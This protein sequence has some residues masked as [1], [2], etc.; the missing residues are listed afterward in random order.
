MELEEGEVL[1]GLC[2]CYQIPLPLPGT[3]LP[4]LLESLLSAVMV[5]DPLIALLLVP[6]C[7]LS[8]NLCFLL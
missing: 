2:D 3:S 6:P 1:P 4:A 5:T 8:Q 7:L